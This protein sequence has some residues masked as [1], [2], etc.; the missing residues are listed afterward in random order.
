MVSRGFEAVR[1]EERGLV[2]HLGIGDLL[3]FGSAGDLATGDLPDLFQFGADRGFFSPAHLEVELCR[4]ILPIL[5]VELSHQHAT[6]RL[7]DGITKGL[8]S[9]SHIRDGDRKRGGLTRLQTIHGYEHRAVEHLGVGHVVALGGA[10][11]LPGDDLA[12]LR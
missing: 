12:R 6:R 10:G 2:E 7:G 11:Q 1:R 8:V 3:A 5:L 9:R 4:E